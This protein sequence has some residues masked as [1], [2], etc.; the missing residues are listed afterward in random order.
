MAYALPEKQQILSVDVNEGSTAYDAVNQ[1]GIT[2]IFTEID[3]E[4]VGMGVFGKAV[5]AKEY[6]VKAGDRVEIYRPL[7]ADP[8]AVRKARAAK[9]AE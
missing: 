9:K 8:K 6:L 4:T 1:S 2:K 5:K 3:L 7:I